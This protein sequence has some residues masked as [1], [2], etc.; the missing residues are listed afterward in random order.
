MD[1]STRTRIRWLTETDAIDVSSYETLRCMN[2]DEY[3]A[4]GP[5][6]YERLAEAVVEALRAALHEQPEPR[7][8]HIQR[9][10]KAEPC[11]RRKSDHAGGPR[12]DN[13]A[14][15]AKDLT[16][17]RLVFYTNSDVARF[18]SSRTLTRIDR[19]EAYWTGPR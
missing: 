17:Y 4:G 19:C 18:Q 1:L 8:Q 11:L 9:R 10:T 7:L 3:E 5:A 14:A 6:R 16:G 12:T 13:P 2:I 15:V